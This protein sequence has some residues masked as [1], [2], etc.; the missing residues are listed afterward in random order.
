MLTWNNKNTIESKAKYLQNIT[1]QVQLIKCRKIPSIE[2]SESPILGDDI[3]VG[4]FYLEAINLGGLRLEE[5]TVDIR[6]LS[7][8]QVKVVHMPL[9]LIQEKK[10]WSRTKRR[11]II[12]N[13]QPY[14]FVVHK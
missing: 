5:R 14:I 11:F 2:H 12:L 1:S 8:D 9:L 10:A 4:R 6:M 3:T 7:S 13:S